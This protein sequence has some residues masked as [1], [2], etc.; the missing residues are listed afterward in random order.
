[1]IKDPKAVRRGM[2]NYRNALEKLKK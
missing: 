1:M 2:E